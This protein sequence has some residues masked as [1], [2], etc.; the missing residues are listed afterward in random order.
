MPEYQVINFTIMSFIFLAGVLGM[1]VG[2]RSSV[3]EPK[4]YTK[5]KSHRRNVG[6]SCFLFASPFRTGQPTI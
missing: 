2:I 1:N 6:G 4:A 3:G 5:S